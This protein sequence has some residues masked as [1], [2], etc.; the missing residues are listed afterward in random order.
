MYLNP[1]TIRL[2]ILNM[3]YNKKS[4]HIGPSFSAVE[5]ISYL[6]ENYNLTSI[7]KNRDRLILSKGHA[8]PVI[9]AILYE[10][11]IIQTLNNFREINSSLQ[12]HPD[13]LRCKY[14]DASTGSLGQGPSIAIGH[15]IAHKKNNWNN[16]IFC[17][18]GD[19]EMQ[20]GQVWEALMFASAKKI[21]N[22]CFLIDHNN[23]QNDGYISDVLDI[24]NL[25]DKIKSF[26]FA[27]STINGHNTKQIHNVIRQH[28][29]RPQCII[30]KTVKGYGVSFMQ[31]P[32]WHSKIP[33]ETEY[34]KAK[35]E[36]IC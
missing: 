20:E 22:L 13:K 21:N 6:Y 12:G 16:R 15:A 5:I 4:G 3:I 8:V 17:L 24:G 25:E 26:N 30:L 33:T 35:E 19:G 10:M 18:I 31:A 32:T 36:L 11:G 34:L 7:S 28:H 27:C 29:E 2:H 23:S 1:T 14:I 9:Y